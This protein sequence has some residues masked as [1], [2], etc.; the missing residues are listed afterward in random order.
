MQ[1]DLNLHFPR[2]LSFGKELINFLLYKSK[3]FSADTDLKYWFC[4]EQRNLVAQ[5]GDPTG[6]GKGGESVNGYL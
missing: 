5:T 3:I 4:F 1:S 6:T 2:H